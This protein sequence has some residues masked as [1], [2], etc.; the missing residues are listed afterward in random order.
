M[1]DRKR[2]VNQILGDPSEE[3]AEGADDALSACMQEM[4]DCIHAKDVAGAASAFKACFEHCES[5]PHEEY[6]E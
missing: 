1:G 2:M 4:I 5:E 3:K 6:G